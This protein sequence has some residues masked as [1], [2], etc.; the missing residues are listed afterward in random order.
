MRLYIC[1]FLSLFTTSYIWSQKRIHIDEKNDTIKESLFQEKWRNKDLGLIR[2]DS[3]SNDGKRYNKLKPGLYQTAIVDYDVIKAE[4][5]QIT[6]IK[7]TDSSEILIQYYYKDD[8]CSSTRDNKWTK[9]EIAYHKILLEPL[10]NNLNKN[11]IIFICF[12]ENEMTLNNNS[13]KNDEFLFL[14]KNNFFRENLFT[15]R[16]LCGSH[17]AI[18]PNGQSLVRN[19]EYRADWFAQ[20]LNTENWSLFFGS[21]N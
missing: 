12:F 8:L 20:Y 18:K 17:A 4:I 7:I 16:A 19:G 1:L 6:P 5:E 9:K 14:D 13:S 21:K 3:I 2:W 10:K 15:N 11:N